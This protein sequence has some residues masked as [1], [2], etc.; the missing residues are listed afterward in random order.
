MAKNECIARASFAEASTP[1]SLMMSR[2]S[3][4]IETVVSVNNALRPID[5]LDFVG[6]SNSVL[7]FPQYLQIA[8]FGCV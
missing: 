5:I 3:E 1:L 7:R 2:G 6:N 4:L 8:I